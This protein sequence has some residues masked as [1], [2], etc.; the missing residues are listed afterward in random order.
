M[1]VSIA[2]SR[3]RR[4]AG[5]HAFKL[6]LALTSSWTPAY[7]SLGAS[8]SRS[9]SMATVARGGLV[10]VPGSV[11]PARFAGTSTMPQ[12]SLEHAGTTAQLTS[13]VEVAAVS[14]FVLTTRL[15]NE[16][17]AT[18]LGWKGNVGAGMV[19]GS[20]CRNL[21][22]RSVMGDAAVRIAGGGTEGISPCWLALW[23]RALTPSLTA[24]P[25]SPSSQRATHPAR[26]SF[27]VV[28]ACPFSSSLV[29]GGLTGTVFQ[30]QLVDSLGSHVV[31]VCQGALVPAACWGQCWVRVSSVL[32]PTMTP[33]A[34]H[35]GR[36]LGEHAMVDGDGAKGPTAPRHRAHD[37]VEPAAV[38]VTSPLALRP[39]PTTSRMFLASRTR[40]TTHI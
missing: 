39:P 28:V 25:S 11:V 34:A 31:R 13:E 36:R 35:G 16:T 12:P 5:L 7:L 9:Q 37:T 15:Q 26:T 21:M 30:C 14:D 18:P 2:A 27:T 38:S 8:P 20:G 19:E 40:L 33:M 1:I 4:G 10:G 22:I 32:L 29:V 3:T 23:I 17:A 6:L 24:T